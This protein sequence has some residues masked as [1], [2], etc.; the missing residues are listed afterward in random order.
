MISLIGDLYFPFPGENNNG[1]LGQSLE[2][3]SA[4]QLVPAEESYLKV[5]GTM[6]HGCYNPLSKT[7]LEWHININNVTKQVENEQIKI[8]QA[9]LLL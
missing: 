1:M 3:N 8:M 2:D 7:Q 9:R 5:N 4:H 6:V